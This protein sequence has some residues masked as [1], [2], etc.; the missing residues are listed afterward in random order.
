M[1]IS[2]AQVRTYLFQS[3]FFFSCRGPTCKTCPNLYHGCAYPLGGIN[4]WAYGLLGEANKILA[5]FLYFGCNC[6]D[7]RVHASLDQYCIRV[8]DLPQPDWRALSSL[9]DFHL[10]LHYTS[11]PCIFLALFPLAVELYF[12]SLMN[13]NVKILFCPLQLGRFIYLRS[14]VIS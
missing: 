1:P 9:I 8:F 6:T 13:A 12:E 5:W 2:S 7:G 4:A 10:S 11:C 3:R 14:S